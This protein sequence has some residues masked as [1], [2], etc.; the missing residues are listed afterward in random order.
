MNGTKIAGAS[1][2]VRQLLTIAVSSCVSLYAA[3][4]LAQASPALHTP[5]I[6]WQVQENFPLFRQGKELD[7]LHALAPTSARDL[8]RKLAARWEP[9]QPIVVPV[10]ST[11][12]DRVAGRYKAGYLLAA[13]EPVSI[14]AV[15]EGLPDRDAQCAWQLVHKADGTQILEVNARCADWA[16][17]YAPLEQAVE[18]NVSVNSSDGR[19]TFTE[20]VFVKQFVTVAF[21][22]SYAAGQGNPDVPAVY[23]GPKSD[24][25]GADWLFTRDF[26]S[27]AS[28]AQPASGRVHESPAQ[29]W[30]NECQRSLVSWPVLAVLVQALRDSDRHTRHVILTYAC[31]GA[32]VIDGGF[33]AQTKSV[34]RARSMGHMRDG[35]FDTRNPD[36]RHLLATTRRS[37]LNAMYD[38]VCRDRVR[39]SWAVAVPGRPGARAWVEGCANPLP[40]DRLLL[41]M[42]GND[43]KFPS[44][45]MGILIPDKPVN[46][47]GSPGLWL[48]RR[49]VQAADLDDALAQAT[50]Y[51]QVYP[52][53]LQA[54][55]E[56]AGIPAGKTVLVRYPN[57]IVT[58]TDETENNGCTAGPNVSRDVEGKGKG[59]REPLAPQRARIRDSNLV[60][61][62]ALPYMALGVGR[63][64][65]V[66]AEVQ[67]VQ[68]FRKVY[69]Q[70]K[71][72]Q[73]IAF[74]QPDTF[75]TK[76]VEASYDG[77][78]L[79]DGR[80]LCDIVE[81]PNSML[82]PFHLCGW[83]IL[84]CNVSKAM[85][86]GQWV[87]RSPSEYRH[88]SKIEPDVPKR[89]M[90][91]SLNEA[92]MAGR[93]WTG[94]KPSS[95][96]VVDALAGAMHP[97]AE[98]QAAAADSVLT[99]VNQ[100]QAPAR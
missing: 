49:L 11:L 65:V 73:D 83:E 52:A 71:G 82:L 5:R 23:H 84:E 50:S 56:A 96:E 35:V 68:T 57:P 63:G 46:W 24:R 9:G 7:A 54:M 4:A 67:E 91:Y 95:V 60:I 47:Y 20:D 53:A 37:Q 72:M 29:W 27:P 10:E 90:V 81:A 42:G 21:G 39:R 79:F 61:G 78:S 99:A 64:W 86:G 58:S 59:Q 44:L 100:S 88:Y 36:S 14:Q 40:I 3:L 41:S 38:D 16:V 77:E 1:R 69:A 94:S 6:K 32:E 66:S 89:M 22:D 43:L 33:H 15:V 55:R 98:A 87:A 30:D 93:S 8:Y 76:M 45:A 17:I 2:I 25:P 26:C 34:I 12:Y 80:R 92:I 51:G 70:I 13:G 75:G 19:R 62:Q 85:G 97:T 31:S 28:C 74:A 18:L 48:F